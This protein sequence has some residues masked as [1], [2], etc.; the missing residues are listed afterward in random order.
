MSAGIKALELKGEDAKKIVAAK[1]HLGSMNAN[2]QM[3]QYVFKRADNGAHVIDMEKQW[4]KLILAAR[5]IAAIENPKDVCVVS[6]KQNGQRAILKFASFVGAASITGRFSPGSFT[7][8][9]QHGYHEP[10]LIIVTDPTIDHQAVREASY[11]NIPVIGLCNVDTST[12]YIDV[13][14][15]CNNNANHSIGL[16]WWFLAREV[17]RLRGTISR[18][19]QWSIMPDLFFFRDQEEIKKQEQEERE[20]ERAEA[21]QNT[22]GDFPG[23]E[24]YTEATAIDGFGGE[25]PKQAED[26]NTTTQTG[27]APAENWDA[28]NDFTVQGGDWAATEGGNWN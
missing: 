20:K 4:E 22:N 9:A 12:K 6:T 17:L 23:M 18:D 27:T 1:M 19:D 10:R 24:D 3:K 7:N 11:V 26:W 15:P 21:E 28:T 16:V 5:A 2:Y 14:I 13:C 8:H 25:E